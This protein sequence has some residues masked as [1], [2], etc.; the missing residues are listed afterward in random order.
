M[1]LLA[2]AGNAEKL[3]YAYLYG[4]D[5]AY[6]GISGF[7]LRAQA[8][9]FSRDTAAELRAIKGD[10]KLYGA[11]N[12]YF[13]DSDIGHLEQAI[14]SHPYHKYQQDSKAC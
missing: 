12:M 6:I 7:S 5:A 11:F 8:D 9:N 2:P 1:E 3:R 13:K 14:D 4:A 10:K